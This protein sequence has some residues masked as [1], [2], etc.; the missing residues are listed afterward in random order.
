M[1]KK[2]KETPDTFYKNQDSENN[3]AES[4]ASKALN[5][6]NNFF[7]GLNKEGIE[8]KE[9]AK[10]FYQML[11]HKLNLNERSTPPTEEEVKAAI[12]Q[13]KDMGRFS[14]FISVS[15]LPGGAFSL[16]GIEILAKK[17]GVKG[18]TFI[19]SAFRTKTQ[20]IKSKK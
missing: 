4:F 8:T 15:I 19:P 9:M 3:N 16:M 14:V 17:L 20:E 11:E 1:K 13:L 18:F 2:T 6:I 7:K 5:S 12:D 10:S